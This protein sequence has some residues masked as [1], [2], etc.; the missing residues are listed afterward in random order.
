MIYPFGDECHNI[1]GSALIFQNEY[2]TYFR[3]LF[4]CEIISDIVDYTDA[5]AVQCNSVKPI[6]VSSIEL[7]Q[8]FGY[9]FIVTIYELP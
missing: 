2:C 4:D 5:Y 7:E 8:F 1:R 9:C 6:G 3:K